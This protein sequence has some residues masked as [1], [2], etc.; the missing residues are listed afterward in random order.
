MWDRSK[1]YGY[2]EEEALNYMRSHNGNL[3]EDNEII[4]ESFETERLTLEEIWKLFPCQSV[5]LVDVEWPHP[6]YP[7]EGNVVS[8]VIKYYHCNQDVA[9]IKRARKEVEAVICTYPESLDGD[10][11]CY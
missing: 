10:L 8:G 6:E 3:P 9:M 1:V 11:F 7:G 5:C 4:V 2:T